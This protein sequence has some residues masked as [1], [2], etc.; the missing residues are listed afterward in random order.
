CGPG[1]H[2][3]RALPQSAARR[4]LPARAVGERRLRGLRPASSDARPISKGVLNGGRVGTRMRVCG[5]VPFA[6]RGE[7]IGPVAHRTVDTGTACRVLDGFVHDVDANPGVE[8]RQLPPGA[9][10]E[11]RTLNTD[12]QIIVV[13][14][15]R[16]LVR[17]RGGSRFREETPARIEGSSVG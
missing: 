7:P 16:A 4:G 9:I 15:E 12:Y 6:V 5:R 14:G 11:V 2:H 13:D 10:I 1:A 17:I 3:G 8:L